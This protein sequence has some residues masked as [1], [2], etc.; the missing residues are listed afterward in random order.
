MPV[1]D[2]FKATARI[3]AWEAGRRTRIPIVAMTAFSMPEDHQR[4]LAEDMDDYI[5]KPFTKEQ[6]REKITRWALT[7]VA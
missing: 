4:C 7:S 1:C 3:R 6:L 2:G 5:S